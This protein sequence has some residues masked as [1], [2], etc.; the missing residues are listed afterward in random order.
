MW[1]FLGAPARAGGF[2][3]PPPSGAPPPPRG[4][5][6]RG[7]RLILSAYKKLA[8]GTATIGAVRRVWQ[9]WDPPDGGAMAGP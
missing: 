7:R 5:A 3:S 6:G 9:G 8:P 2:I 1:V 4:A